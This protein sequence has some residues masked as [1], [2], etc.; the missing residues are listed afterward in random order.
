MIRFR[1]LWYEGGSRGKQGPRVYLL[2]FEIQMES[3]KSTGRYSP[4]P[5]K[6]LKLWRE[7]EILIIWDFGAATPADVSLY[8]FA[9]LLG[10][11]EVLRPAAG[12]SPWGSV[13]GGKRDC[14]TPVPAGCTPKRSLRFPE[15]LYGQEMEKLFSCVG[16]HLPNRWRVRARV[17]EQP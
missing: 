8:L 10:R 13:W 17:N 6:R 5:S 3:L 2:A 14:E 7:C 1:S 15:F 4:A 9:S 16:S 11:R 12:E